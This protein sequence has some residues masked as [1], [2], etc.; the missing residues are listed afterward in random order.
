[1]EGAVALVPTTA[2]VI[3]GRLFLLS[4]QNFMSAASLTLRAQPNDAAAV[5]RRAL[6]GARLAL[7]IKH[8]KANLE[9]WIAFEK[10]MSRW[11]QR[12]E[13]K[14]PQPFRP[15][16]TY[17]PQNAICEQLGRLVGMLSDGAAHFTPEFF[18]QQA[19]RRD[20]TPNPTVRLGFFS[21]DQ[22]TI[23]QGLAGL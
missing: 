21:E 14:T 6:E 15:E 1:Y 12:T 10:R 2:P 20:L 17:P 4:H 3:F 18:D 5:T 13:G 11:P 9:R 19:W 22:H 7:A 16:L 8:D 23:E